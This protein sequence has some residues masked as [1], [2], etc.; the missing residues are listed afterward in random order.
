[1]RI[2]IDAREFSTSSGRY[3]ERLVTY[4]Q[5]IDHK[6]DYY[7]L[8][9]SQDFERWE[10][11][12]ANFNKVRCDIKEF[13]FSEQLALRKQIKSLKPDLV[14]FAF[15]Q[16]P[17]LYRGKVITTIHDLT[18]LRFYNPSKN[19]VIFKIKQLVYGKV[20]KRAV[21]KSVSV[22]TPTNFVKDDVANY[23]NI[24]PGKVTVTYESADPITENAEVFKGLANKKFIMY[25]GRP[26]PHKNLPRLIEAFT[27]LKKQYPELKL[28]LA[29]KKDSNYIQ[30][31]NQTKQDGIKDIIFT[32]FISDGQLK[33]LY[34]NCAAYVFPSLSEG[35]G[36]PGLE[37]M[38]CGAVVASSDATCLPEVYGDAALYFDPLD[39]SDMARAIATAMDDEKLRSEL[40]SKSKVLLQKYS[41]EKMAKQTLAIYEKSI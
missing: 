5:K 18:T 15:A 10:P 28:V 24:N 7:I 13:T 11:V 9:K 35:F 29:G 25:I 34:Q 17:I 21:R 27:I 40:I 20:I 22:I 39:S 1:M 26:T 31:D 30:I 12:S 37:A 8:L 23:S 14:H 3:V 36:L 16:Q 6:N 38:Q 4:L 2:V 41:W 32:D 33:W 19:F